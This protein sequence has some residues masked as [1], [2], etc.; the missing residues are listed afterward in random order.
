MDGGCFSARVGG[1][2]VGK[3]L[4]LLSK[5]KQAEFGRQRKYIHLQN[6]NGK[7]FL[8]NFFIVLSK[9]TYT[10]DPPFDNRGAEEFLGISSILLSFVLLT[11]LPLGLVVNVCYAISA[12]VTL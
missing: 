6:Q 5:L 4:W 10:D 12:E 3:A 7:P 1:R 8:V 11:C 9:M 2:I